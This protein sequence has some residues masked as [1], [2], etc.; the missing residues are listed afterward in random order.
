MRGADDAFQE[1]LRVAFARNLH[2]SVAVLQGCVRRLDRAYLNHLPPA[3]R[4]A[5][6][7]IGGYR[8]LILGLG[9]FVAQQNAWSLDVPDVPLPGVHKPLFLDIPR[10]H[11]PGSLLN[12]RCLAYEAII[13]ARQSRAFTVE[14]VGEY[15]AMGGRL[16][17]RGEVLVV[18][19]DYSRDV[20]DMH[21]IDDA[22]KAREAELDVRGGAR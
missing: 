8:D 4:R 10:P 7:W 18:E 6:T 22:L 13:A 11:V 17:A 9:A 20:L 21:A 15:N 19:Y 1:Q 3:V 5:H 16:Q 14:R 12:A 2:A